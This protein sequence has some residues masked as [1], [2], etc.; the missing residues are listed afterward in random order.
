MNKKV[1][2]SKEKDFLLIKVRGQITN[3]D[4]WQLYAQR[5]YIEASKYNSTDILI[6]GRNLDLLFRE[7]DVK[8]LIRSYLEE[9]PFEIRFYKIAVVLKPKWKHIGD[10][11]AYKSQ[12]NG[13][14]YRVFYS[15]EEAQ[16]YLKGVG[17]MN[18]QKSL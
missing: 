9:L 15:M 7:V 17:E 14:K 12:C 1:T 16:N 5:C 18:Y 3:L 8:G 2:A 10:C 6:D 11:W 13:F 4:D